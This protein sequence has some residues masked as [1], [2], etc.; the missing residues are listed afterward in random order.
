MAL[1]ATVTTSESRCKDKSRQS[2]VATLCYPIPRPLFILGW[3]TCWTPAVGGLIVCECVYVRV[4]ESADMSPY[5]SA[6]DEWL[7][8]KLCMYVGYHDANNVS[9]FGCDSVTQ[10]H[11]KKTLIFLYFRCFKSTAHHSRNVAIGFAA[12]ATRP[13][14]GC[15]SMEDRRRHQMA[16]PS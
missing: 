6:H 13:R 8:M 2:D 14:A 15:W 16:I 3:P 11:F 4:C 9:H 12:G 7:I 1:L 10:L 5:C